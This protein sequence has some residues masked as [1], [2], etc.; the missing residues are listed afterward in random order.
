MLAP[1]RLS[2]VEADVW[3]MLERSLEHRESP[4]RTPVVATTGI[5][6]TPQA[7]TV[8]LRRV[9]ARSHA[10]EFHTD[11][12]SPKVAELARL[13]RVSWLFYDPPRML[14]VR[15][16]SVASV[17]TQG[18]AADAAWAATALRSRAPYLAEHDAGSPIDAPG[19]AVFVRDEQ[20]SLQGR[21]HFCLVRCAVLD[22]DV[23][24]LHPHGHRRARV[25]DGVARWVAP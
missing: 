24:Q 23:L 3:A 12:R 18:A 10:L 13:D 4:L 17:L 6:G 19:P 8:V 14:Q 20:H 22:L 16:G 1:I 9:D 7:R 2:T 5:D 21:A 25:L 15:V 11:A